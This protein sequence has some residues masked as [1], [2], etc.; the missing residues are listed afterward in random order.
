[1]GRASVSCSTYKRYAR[2]TD[3]SCPLCDSF[4]RQTMDA[5][6]II[7]VDGGDPRATRPRKFCIRRLERVD[8]RAVQMSDEIIRIRGAQ[9]TTTLSACQSRGTELSLNAIQ[10]VSESYSMKR[11]LIRGHFYAKKLI[12]RPPVTRLVECQ[13]NSSFSPRFFATVG[14]KR[15]SFTFQIV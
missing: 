8:V 4:G 2:E 5:N 1:M 3:T 6:R 14:M 10:P 9:P 13:F 11:A 12:E 15:S 7:V